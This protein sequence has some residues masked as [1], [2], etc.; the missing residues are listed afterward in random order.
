MRDSS[1]A[2]VRVIGGDARPPLVEAGQEGAGM[3]VTAL[4]PRGTLERIDE[5]LEFTHRSADLG[6]VSD[7][8]AET[9]YIVL[10]KQT[11]E[12]VYQRV[13]RDLRARYT[14]WNDLLVADRDEVEALIAPAGFQRQR[15]DHLLGILQAVAG[16]NRA[17]GTGPWRNPEPQDLNLDFL[18]E[19]DP[20]EAE[21]FLTS[22]PGVGTKS[23]RCVIAYALEQQAF[24]VDTHVHRIF[25][26]LGLTK[27]NGRKRDHNPFQ[28]L[29]PPTMRTRLH[30]NLVHH[31]RAVCRTRKARCGECVLV[32]FCAEGRNAIAAE[33]GPVAVDLFAGAGGLG[34][35]FRQAGFRIGLAVEPDRHAAQTYRLN[36]P[37][38][39]VIEAKVDASTTSRHL[40]RYMPSAGKITALLA[41]PPCQGYSAAGARRPH[42]SINRLYRHVSRLAKEL[43]VDAVCLENVPGVQRVNGH[44]FLNTMRNSLCRAGFATE[45]YLVHACEYGVPQHRARYFFLGKRGE[46]APIKPPA[47]HRPRHA[48][49]TPETSELPPTPRLIDLFSQL[50]E[51]STGVL[52]ERVS[53]GEREDYNL[54]TMAHGPAVVEKIRKIKPGAGPISYRRLE[55]DEAR[56]LIAG[57]R[58]M[59]VHPKHHRTISVREAAVIQGFP[60]D[61]VF[62]GPRAEQPLQVANAVPPPLAEAVARTIL[63]CLQGADAAAGRETNRQP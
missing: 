43:E 25:V 41:G 19:V 10:S 5:L 29:V 54:S 4:D 49:R 18:R 15:T 38:V 34:Y 58:A 3:K 16:A 44:G 6:N 63:S 17:R 52:A 28:D 59:P 53:G 46:K 30:I 12:P 37:G 51:I 20:G 23:A 60:R 45:A 7:P 42:A 21:Q 55:R 32:S 39:P 47:T 24:P 36:N 14:E 13:F 62:C 22:L 56:T 11:R 1:A 2:H 27:S 31:G 33:P 61:Y 8:L 40:R 26:R 50:P 57:H 9:I 35:G 48:Q